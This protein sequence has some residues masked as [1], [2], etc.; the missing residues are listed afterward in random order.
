MQRPRPSGSNADDAASGAIQGEPFVKPRTPDADAQAAWHQVM[1]VLRMLE[2]MV[3]AGAR[4]RLTRSKVFPNADH[5]DLMVRAIVIMIRNI[6][7][8]AE[9]VDDD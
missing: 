9:V 5:S 3:A 8:N 1:C 7:R 4:V 2:D 6:L